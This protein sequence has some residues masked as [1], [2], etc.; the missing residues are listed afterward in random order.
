MD[1]TILEERSINVKICPYCRC[2][3]C[4]Y[5]N[6]SELKLEYVCGNPMCTCNFGTIGEMK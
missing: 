4:Y 2:N 3:L 6:A 5:F 1:E